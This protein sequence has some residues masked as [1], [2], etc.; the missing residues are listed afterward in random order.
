[1]ASVVRHIPADHLLSAE[2]VHVSAAAG[3][4]LT[5]LQGPTTNDEL[6]VGIVKVAAGAQ[7]PA[8]SH[9][10]GQVIVCVSGEGFVELDGERVRVAKGDVVICPA[11]EYHIH[12]AAADQSWEHLTIS[13]GTHGG[14]RTE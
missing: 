3:L 8:H 5:W 4:D 6:D 13:T 12:G 7:S 14:A 2:G 11:G 1:M 9:S 10:K